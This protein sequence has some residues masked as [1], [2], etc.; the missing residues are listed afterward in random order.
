MLHRSQNLQE[1]AERLYEAIIAS[2]GTS[3]GTTT[4][5]FVEFAG[6]VVA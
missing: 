1:T 6:G 5:V 4:V 3:D 2:A